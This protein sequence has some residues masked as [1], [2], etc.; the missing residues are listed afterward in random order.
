[1]L[2]YFHLTKLQ[3]QGVLKWSL[4]GLLTLLVLLLQTVVLAKLP[5]LGIKLTPLPALIGCVCVR[6]GPE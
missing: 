2:K 6:E 1:M 5:V 3:W 4:Y